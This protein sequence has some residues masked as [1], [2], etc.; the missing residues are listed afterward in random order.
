MCGVVLRNGTLRSI[1]LYHKPEQCQPRKQQ[2]RRWR[3][4]CL[5]PRSCE[6]LHVPARQWEL[7]LDQTNLQRVADK[8]LFCLRPCIDMPLWCA[9]TWASIPPPAVFGAACYN[10][11]GYADRPKGARKKRKRQKER[12]VASSP[13][14]TTPCPPTWYNCR[15]NV[16]MVL[17]GHTTSHVVLERDPTS[18]CT[19]RLHT[20]TA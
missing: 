11:L 3:L 9:P 14:F 6:W 12:G 8:R 10:G 2:Q 7:L 5:F 16:W 13:S 19:L 1:F 18:G 15:L 4:V 17:K 20:C